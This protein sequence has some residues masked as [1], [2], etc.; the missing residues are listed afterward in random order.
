VLHHD[1]WQRQPGRRRAAVHAD[2]AAAFTHRTRR[3]VSYVLSVRKFNLVDLRHSLQFPYRLSG[4]ECDGDEADEEAVGEG[5]Y[6][7]RYRKSRYL[8]DLERAGYGEDV[9]P[10]MRFHYGIRCDDVLID[11]VT[12]Q[13]PEIACLGITSR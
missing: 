13:A 7:A 11:V 5:I 10:G 8:D 1:G 4:G 9:D 12:K 2:E 3:M 6:F